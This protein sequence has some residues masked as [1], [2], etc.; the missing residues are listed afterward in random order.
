MVILHV[1]DL[2]VTSV[3][4]HELIAAFDDG[5]RRVRLTSLLNGCFAPLRDPVRF[6]E[7]YVASPGVPT[8]PTTVKPD[9]A[10]DAEAMELDLAPEALKDAPSEEFPT[11]S[12]AAKTR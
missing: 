11:R 2:E 7:V 8:W 4:V 12:A 9:G 5:T 10:P 3:E 1:T 6:A